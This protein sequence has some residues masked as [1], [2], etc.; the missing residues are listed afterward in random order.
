MHSPKD[1]LVTTTSTL[2]NLEIK[3]Y[4]KPISAQ[5]VAGAGFLSDFAASF[6]D[7]FGGRSDTYQNR[8]TS[9]YDEAIAKLKREA[10]EIGANC[11]VGLSV[12]MDEISGKGKEMFMITA[13]GTAVIVNNLSAKN[14]DLP[15]S[16]KIEN[17]SI[18]K[19]KVLQRKR[20][21]LSQA[22]TGRMTLTDDIWDFITANQIDE[23][24]EFILTQLKD[25]IAINEDFAKIY[26]NTI[27]FL[28]A[29]PEEKKLNLIYNSILKEDNE[30]INVK[31][32]EIIAKLKLFDFPHI[33]EILNS[34]DFT[35]QKRALRILGYDKA[36]Y[37]KQDVEKFRLLITVIKEKFPERGAR[38]MKKQLLSS[39]EKEIW[40]CEC[41]KNNGI[42]SHCSSCNK[43]IH[44]FTLYEVTPA[45]SILK[46]EEKISLIL[47]FVEE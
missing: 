1:I 45:Q 26:K 29:L 40:L 7:L 31:L 34:T 11:I 47:E 6:T 5:I 33:D 22:N 36:F 42:G 17:V 16:E 27:S 13:I 14:E 9:L 30:Q 44:G 23:I 20:E 18:D 35:K 8:L 37:N 4:L 19:L 10:Y 41:G 25:P 43:D 24:F 12:D 28:D 46:I 2:Q 38:S 3:Q 15:S 21:I 39:K 32:C